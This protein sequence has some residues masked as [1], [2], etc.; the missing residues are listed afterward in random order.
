MEKVIKN[1]VIV[2]GGSAGWLTAGLLAARHNMDQG[3]ALANPRITITLIESPDVATIGVGE[4][5]WPSMRQTL[6]TLGISETAFL[7]E[8]DASFKQ[9]SLFRGWRTGDVGRDRYLH[10]F[11]LPSGQ[12]ELNLCEH[13]LPFREQV[14]FAD[15]VCGQTQPALTGLAPKTISTPEFHFHNNYG[16][17]LDAGKFGQL[18][19]AHCTN[20]LGVRYLPAH[21]DSVQSDAQGD[22][23]AVVTRQHG[24]VEGDLFIDCSGARSLLLGQHLDVPLVEQHSVLF[25]DR[26]LAVQVPYENAEDP[27]AS[28]TVATANGSGWIWDIGLSSRRGVGAVYASAFSNEADAEQQL[29]TYLGLDQNA[30]LNARSLQFTPGYRAVCWKNNCMAIGMA[31]GFIEPLEASALALIE[32]MASALAEQLPPTRATLPLI[33]QRMNRLHQ[34]Q[35]QQVIEFLKLHYVVSHRED[36]PYWRAHRDASSIPSELQEKLALWRHRAPSDADISQKRPLFPAASYQYVLYGMGFDTANPVYIKPSQQ[37]K[38]L[39]LFDEN[40]KRTHELLRTLPNNRT[41]INKV[42]QFGFQKI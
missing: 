31:A 11:T 15:A 35:W 6:A 8:C 32:T 5:T 17:H 29:R 37:R 13:W 38:A 24:P 23:A 19:Q 40:R 12:P 1:V 16:Y 41:L 36:S 27:I 9:G 22:I 7:L 2:G 20:R 18:L 42:R 25:N 3:Q 33:A 10:P 39:T 21:I 30:T 26:A 34:Q 14:A 4:G 28:C